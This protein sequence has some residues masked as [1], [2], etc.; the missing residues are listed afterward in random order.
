V[1]RNQ[2]ADTFRCG[3]AGIRGRFDGS[4]VA[5]H[6]HG[7]QTAADKLSADESDFRCFNHCIGG[8]NSA[9]QTPGFHH[10]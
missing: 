1:Y 10:T 5:T 7:N 6:K 4:D 8:L 3:A 9:G 2:L